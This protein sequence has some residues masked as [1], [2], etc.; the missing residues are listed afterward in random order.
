MLVLSRKVGEQITIGEGVVVTITSLR[1]GVV[2]LGITAP[3]EVRVMRT[4]IEGVLTSGSGP[5]AEQPAEDASVVDA[6]AK[7]NAKQATR[8]ITK[9]PKL[10]PTANSLLSMPTQIVESEVLSHRPLAMHM[11]L[12]THSA[13]LSGC[14]RT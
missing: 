4:E 13:E 8:R 14:S 1:G 11:R 9:A 7:P 12:R 2:K 6:D 5:K 10:E 3:R